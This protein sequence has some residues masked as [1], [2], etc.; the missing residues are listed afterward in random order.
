MLSEVPLLE[1]V[2]R[3]QWE[4]MPCWDTMLRSSGLSTF[5]ATVTS[6]HISATMI[7]GRCW[8]EHIIAQQ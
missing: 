4:Q 1:H 5:W 8:K 7:Y 6:E 2:V 3:E